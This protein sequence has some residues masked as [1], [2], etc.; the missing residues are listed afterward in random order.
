M[1]SGISLWEFLRYASS[2]AY[3]CILLLFPIKVI[4]HSKTDVCHL[5]FLASL[6]STCRFLFYFIKCLHPNVSPKRAIQTDL[7]TIGFQCPVSYDGYTY[8]GVC[9]IQDNNM[10]LRVLRRK[11]CSRFVTRNEE[12]A[13]KALI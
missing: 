1:C 10:T 9:I 12:T 7:N 6:S 4:F 3:V 13:Q 2:L 5:G 8:I 11:S